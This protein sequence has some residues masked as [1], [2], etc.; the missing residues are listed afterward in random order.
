MQWICCQLG[1]REHYAVP[2]ALL[3]KGSLGQFITDL[4]IRPGTLLHSWPKQLNGRFHA[5]LA[6]AAVSAANIASLTFELQAQVSGRNGWHLIRRRNEWFQRQA[7][8]QLAQVAPRDTD[9]V[10]AYSYAAAEIFEFARKRGWRTVL[11]QIDPGPTEERIVAGLNNKSASRNPRWEPAPK[12]YWDSWRRECELADRI[13]VNSQWSQQAL[14]Q[15][16][17]P[18]EKIRLVPL[19][20]EANAN[21]GSI[22]REYPRAFSASRPLQVLF[23]GQINLRKGVAELFDAINFL[24]GEPLEFWFVGPVQIDVPANLRDAA[25]V[26][27]VGVVPRSEAAKYYREADVFLLP[28]LSDGFGLTQLEAQ[29]W[30]LP[31]VSSR[32]CGEVVRDGSNGV[33][34]EEVSG[35]AIADVM[36]GFLR[37]PELLRAMSQNSGVGSRFSLETFGASL[38]NL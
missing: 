23:L 34:L 15:E 1:A 30:R 26:K 36:R 27:W 13:V 21:S 37:A 9:T 38:I 17:I 32:N 35:K 14:L 19:A 3:S 18:A 5:G 33:L 28:T 31:V 12:E 4:W 10:F 29:S 11:G 6:E 8:A 22:Q 2:R 25:N 20:Y 24:E 7:V 16:G